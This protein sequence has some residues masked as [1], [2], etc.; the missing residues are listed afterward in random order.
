VAGRELPKTLTSDE[1]TAL[2]GRCNLTAPTGLRDRA[3]LALMHRAGLRVSE[4]CGLHLRDIDWKQ[5][6]VHVRPEVGKGGKEAVQP[7][8]GQTLAL[9]ERWKQVRRTYAAGKPHLFTTLKGG[10]VSRHRVWEMTARRARRAGIDRPVW[11]HM[12]RHTYATE[13]L[14]DGF[15]V[16]EVQRLMRHS[17]IRTTSVYLHL[18]DAE[19]SA[20]VRARG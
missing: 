9:L 15:N 10:P 18:H 16:V 2:M 19:L 8:D 20:K 7:L 12:L 11:P 3:M 13:L 4:V 17:D 1:V 14:R 6:T 5:G